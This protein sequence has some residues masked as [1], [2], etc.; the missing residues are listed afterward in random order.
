MDF[1]EYIGIPFVPNGRSKAGTDCWHLICLIYKEQLNIILPSYE[2]IKLT[3]EISS[4]LQITRAFRR[5]KLNWK[6]VEK[7]EPYDVILIR[8]GSMLYHAGLVIGNG[9]MLHID[10]GI[11]STIE[12]YT[13]IMW[14]DKIEGFYRYHG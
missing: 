12:K 11:N 5:N 1:N 13:S 4:L 6:S 14:K 2:K 8:T 7:P 10:R 9:R 3:D